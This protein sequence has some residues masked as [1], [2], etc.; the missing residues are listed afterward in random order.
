M[1]A[2]TLASISKLAQRISN[3]GSLLPLNRSLELS[4]DSVRACSE[5]GNLKILVGEDTGLTESC[6]INVNYAVNILS[7]L[8]PE[9]TLTLAKNGNKVNWS[10]GEA[11]G[12][13]TLVEQEQKILFPFLAK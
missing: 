4:K 3:P 1:L 10:C 11:K 8:G 6:L 7:S 12:H 2:G 13:L 5:F 9:S